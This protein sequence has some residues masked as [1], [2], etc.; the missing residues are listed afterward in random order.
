[1]STEADYKKHV[2]SMPDIINNPD[3]VGLHP[4]GNSI[5]YIKRIDELMLVAIR[6][7]LKGK[8]VVRSSYPI[9][10]N[11]LDSY[12]ASGSVKEIPKNIDL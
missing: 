4:K 3:Y 5:Q 1:M 11:T 10:Q 2:E 7:T 6:I 9:T 8:L 12:L